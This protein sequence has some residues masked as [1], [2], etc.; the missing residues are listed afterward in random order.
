MQDGYQA[1]RLLLFKPGKREAK[2]EETVSCKVCPSSAQ[3]CLAESYGSEPSPT[4]SFY[5]PTQ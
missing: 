2:M 5:K 1:G 4:W 3:L